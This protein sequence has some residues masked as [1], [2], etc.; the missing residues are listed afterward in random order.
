M[1]VVIADRDLKVTQALSEHVTVGGAAASRIR[2]NTVIQP[3]AS[4]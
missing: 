4:A 1:K 2:N 3:E